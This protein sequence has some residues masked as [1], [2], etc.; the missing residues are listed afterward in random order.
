MERSPH[1]PHRSPGG[2]PRLY[3]SSPSMAPAD[4]IR[5]SFDQI[6]RATPVNPML[7]QQLRRQQQAAMQPMGT[8]MGPPV[9]ASPPS[10]SSIHPLGVSTVHNAPQGMINTTGASPHRFQSPPYPSEQSQQPV[11]YQ[12]QHVSY[13]SPPKPEADRNSSLPS[14]SLNSSSNGIAGMAPAASVVSM[15][16]P[17]PVAGGSRSRRMASSSMDTLLALGGK[18]PITA[19]VPG[20]VPSIRPPEVP[21]SSSAAAASRDS[22]T[23]AYPS[24]S[25]SK[26]A[27]SLSVPATK[28]SGQS[29]RKSLGGRV[30][31]PP[32]KVVAET[33]PA[34][35][36]TTTR[37][38]RVSKPVSRIVREMDNPASS[39]SY[40]V[41]KAVG[42]DAKSTEDPRERRKSFPQRSED[43]PVPTNSIPKHE[44]LGN[45][46]RTSH[47]SIDPPNNGHAKKDRGETIT[48]KEATKVKPNHRVVDEDEDEDFVEERPITNKPST[49]KVSKKKELSVGDKLQAMIAE[50]DKTLASVQSRNVTDDTQEMGR[51]SK[52]WSPTEVVALYAVYNKTDVTLPNCWQIISERLQKEKNILRT[53]EECKE[54]WFSALQDVKKRQERMHQKKKQNQVEAALQKLQTINEQAAEKLGMKIAETALKGDHSLSGKGHGKKRKANGSVKMPKDDSKNEDGHVD[55]AGSSEEDSE[56][57]AAAGTKGKKATGNTKRP[58]LGKNDLKVRDAGY[59]WICCRSTV[60]AHFSGGRVCVCVCTGVGRAFIEGDE[61]R[62]CL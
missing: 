13:S 33:A 56:D 47:Q 25:R 42:H 15:L 29:S 1:L 28:P 54:K 52:P 60:S 57:D 46:N 53:E 3:G 22:E 10:S 31:P 11:P 6:Y 39:T 14:H 30:Q 8:F 24:M 5:M 45:M 50:A 27:P 40:T 9:Y 62:R 37:S 2:D 58:R 26:S 32:S 49:N 7:A 23:S 12:A 35:P 4:V 61:R 34:S 36:P 44:L 16:P 21:S 41:V 59:G 51:K 38:G 48:K 55:E 20:A 43:P 18:K 19:A 17:P